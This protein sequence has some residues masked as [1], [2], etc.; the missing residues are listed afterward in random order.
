MK[1]PAAIRLPE[2]QA[3]LFHSL[4]DTVF[5][6]KSLKTKWMILFLGTDLWSW[7]AKCC[8]KS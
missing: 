8:R 6:L 5:P 2:A 4:R 1:E 3:V 7:G